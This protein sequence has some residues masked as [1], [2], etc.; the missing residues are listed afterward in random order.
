MDTIISRLKRLRLPFLT[1]LTVYFD[2]GTSKT[3]IAIKD[4]GI[5]LKESSYIGLNTRTNEPIFFG[6]EARAIEGKTPDFVQIVRPVR[7]GILCD[8]DAEVAFIQYCIN[9]AVAP[10]LSAYPLLKP[11]LCAIVAVPKIATEIEERAIEEVMLKTGFSSVSLIEKPLATAAGC[12]FQIFSHN[13]HLIVDFG[14][15]LT[16]ISIIS[17][18]GVMTM[19]TIRHGGIEFN[20]LLAQYLHLKYNIVVPEIIYI[21][22]QS[23]DIVSVKSD[24]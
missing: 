8:F 13:P 1:Q 19:R 12:G 7:E 4:K 9:R 2:L 23:S 22:Y 10:Y 16:E 18:G 21:Q 17:G 15:G 6:N 20:K 24:F 14:A 3:R 11:A 5:V